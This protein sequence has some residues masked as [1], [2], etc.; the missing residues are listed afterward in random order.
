MIGVDTN[1]IR[2]I[3]ILI[4]L[5]YYREGIMD[6]SDSIEFGKRI[7]DLREKSGK[8]QE[9]ICSKLGVTQQT[10]SRYEKGQRK[11][12][13]KFVVKASKYFNVST[14]YLLGITDIKT[15][16]RDIRYIHE[17]TGLDEISISTLNNLNNVSP[18]SDVS[19][20][21]EID[22]INLLLSQGCNT[23]KA[24][25]RCY[26][27]LKD[28]SNNILKILTSI[29]NLKYIKSDRLIINDL[30]EIEKYNPII[31]NDSHLNSINIDINELLGDILFDKLKESIVGLR[32]ILKEDLKNG[33]NN[34]QKE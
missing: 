18:Q 30:G 16:N 15:P 28:D 12:S 21:N 9:D 20:F 10:L 24:D 11:A 6:N 25:D 33:C 23:Y 8:S 19:H 27:T 32:K 1:Q 22:I 2:Q 31:Y 7:L 17:Y 13:T 3:S 29:M 26:N 5:H 34:S 4:H 14:D